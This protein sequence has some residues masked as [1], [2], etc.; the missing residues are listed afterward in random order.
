MTGRTEEIIRRGKLG[1]ESFPAH[2]TFKIAGI[3]AF[4]GGF[5]DAYTYILRG[6]VF[7]NAQTG[8]MV[9]AAMGLAEGDLREAFIPVVPILAFMLGVFVTEVIKKHCRAREFNMW[10][11]LVILVEIGLL[12]MVG[13]IPES[14]PDAFANVTVSF[15][16]SIQVCSFKKVRGL[17]YASTMCTGN[18]RSG[19]ESLFRG[20]AEK[21]R[22]QMKTAWHYFGIIALFITGAFLGG[23]FSK[24]LGVK[25]IWICCIA[26]AG[27]F[28][29][30]TCCGQK[31]DL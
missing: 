30:I 12:I 31:K 24:I 2:E 1:L 10:E 21:N 23:I 13:F 29:I 14:V 3:L 18:L 20:I 19:T 8:N 4:V 27:V 15:I 22:K 5:L 6:H 28:I 25:S 26:L 9:L 17:S 16:C 7:A 11:H